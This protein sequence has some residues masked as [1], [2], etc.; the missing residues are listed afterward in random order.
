MVL[1]GSVAVVVVGLW[2]VVCLLGV[3]VTVL[4]AG[5]WME[6]LKM[7]YLVDLLVLIPQPVKG[8]ETICLLKAGPPF[9]RFLKSNSVSSP[10][11]VLLQQIGYQIKAEIPAHAGKVI[12]I[13]FQ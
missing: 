8:E 9:L 13:C 12:N 6:P 1:V 7:V 11:L 10:F 3:E 4:V 2:V 5:P